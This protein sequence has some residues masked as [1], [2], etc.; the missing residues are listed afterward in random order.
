MK[1]NAKFKPKFKEGILRF[2]DEL[3]LWRRIDKTEV[4]QAE[5]GEVI[6]DKIGEYY[7]ANNGIKVYTKFK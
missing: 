7:I 4:F 6:K 1:Y 5:T 3:G 2:Q